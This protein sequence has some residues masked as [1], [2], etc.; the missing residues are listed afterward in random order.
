MHAPRIPVFLFDRLLSLSSQVESW[1][2]P[3]HKEFIGEPCS[4]YSSCYS[5]LLLLTPGYSKGVKL[6]TIY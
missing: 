5:T 1:V 3:T 6:F 4:V 2:S